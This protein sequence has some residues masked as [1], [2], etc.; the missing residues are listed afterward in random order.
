MI[1]QVPIPLAPAKAAYRTSAGAVAVGRGP[2]HV[3]HRVPVVI[4]VI[5]VG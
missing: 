1:P 5:I 4:V 2:W 3:A